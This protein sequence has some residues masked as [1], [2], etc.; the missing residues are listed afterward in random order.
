MSVLAHDVGRL[1]RDAERVVPLPLGHRRH[2]HRLIH[3]LPYPLQHHLD[4][5]ITSRAQEQIVPILERHG[6]QLVLTGHEH[7]Y[8]RT[9]SAP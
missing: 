6:V 7:T 1:D 9:L 2:G 4:D 5:P 3:H 8:Q